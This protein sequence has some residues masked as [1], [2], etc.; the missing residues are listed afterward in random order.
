[1]TRVKAE[2]DVKKR[3]NREKN[4]LRRLLEIAGIGKPKSDILL[5]VVENVSWMRVKL[6]DIRDEI[7]NSEIVIEYNNGGGQKGV[8][9]NPAYTAY[10][11]LWKAYMS[12][13]EKILAALP[14][15]LQ[16]E[17]KPDE[18]AKPRTVLELVREKRGA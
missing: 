1:M 6:D 10:G 17:A 16:E 12:G 2:N 15:D 13:M 5:P 3:A 8:R 4:R 11:K 14:E 7:K 9:E 18:E